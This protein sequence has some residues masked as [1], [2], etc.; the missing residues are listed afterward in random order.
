MHSY[1]NTFHNDAETLLLRQTFVY[2]RKCFL[3]LRLSFQL[4]LKPGLHYENATPF[5]SL[6][7]FINQYIAYVRSGYRST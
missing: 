4:Q 6:T 5:D 3:L 1:N 7:N 2:G